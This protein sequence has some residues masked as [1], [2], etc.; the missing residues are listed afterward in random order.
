[1]KLNHTIKHH[2]PGEHCPVRSVL[3]DHFGDEH[4]RWLLWNETCY[5]LCDETALWQ[6]I[7][8]V[9]RDIA[10]TVRGYVNFGAS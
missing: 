3:F 7:E 5:P 6:A 1:M 8:L 9:D 4:G 10:A 2:E